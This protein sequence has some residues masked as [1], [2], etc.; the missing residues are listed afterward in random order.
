MGSERSAHCS[1]L[2]H[3]RVPSRRDGEQPLFELS[4]SQL[5]Q[6]RGDT[7]SHVCSPDPRVSL[8]NQE[9]QSRVV[10]ERVIDEAPE[11]PAKPECRTLE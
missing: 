8:G 3:A 4:K 6:R 7:S 10:N 11:T 2:G 9:C 5:E 1:S